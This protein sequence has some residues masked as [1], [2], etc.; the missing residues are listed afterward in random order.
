MSSL[1]QITIHNKQ[2]LNPKNLE[3]VFKGCTFYIVPGVVSYCLEDYCKWKINA[4]TCSVPDGE[5]REEEI[6]FFML[7]TLYHEA[8]AHWV[9]EA[10][11]YLPFVRELFNV[12]EK[13]ES[14]HHRSRKMK[15]LIRENASEKRTYKKLFIEHFGFDFERDVYV[16][17]DASFPFSKPLTV[18]FPLPIPSLNT[19][20][21]LSRE[22]VYILD[23]FRFYFKDIVY[24]NE[25][26]YESLLMPRSKIENFKP[27]DRIVDTS[28]FEPHVS[29]ILLSENI[30]KLQSQADI[31]SRAKNIVIPD[32]SAFLVN[33]FLFTYNSNIIVLDK[34]T[35]RQG[36]LYNK[37]KY[38]VD[39]IIKENK[40]TVTY[41][42]PS[43]RRDNWYL[44]LYKDTLKAFI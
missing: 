28:D 3:L 18:I 31:V 22:Y 34:I 36:A 26:C 8:F 29:D 15:I 27:N 21:E 35:E 25:K 41:F 17:E 11:I 4:S 20:D 42:D 19:N 38:L 10:A 39:T 2:D 5:D 12:Y 1:T 30:T 37:M 23:T 14:F 44:Y 33:C 13:G 43:S 6:H 32:G 16:T 24:K 7:D 40:N 9:F